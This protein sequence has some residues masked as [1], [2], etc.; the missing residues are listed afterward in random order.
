MSLISCINLWIPVFLTDSE[1][2]IVYLFS[3][4]TMNAELL[5]G[6]IMFFNLTKKL[7]KFH[8]LYIK[9]VSFFEDV[10]WFGCHVF[11]LKLSKWIKYNETKFETK[12]VLQMYSYTGLLLTG[13]FNVSITC[14]E[15]DSFP[16][17]RYV[18]H[19]SHTTSESFLSG[20]CNTWGSENI[21]IF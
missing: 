18:Y 9:V 4:S 15:R 11:V 1:I 8:R 7:K 5:I 21:C 17:N 16:G 13:C 2:I 12:V 19:V 14:N 3:I 6:G 10:F 20:R